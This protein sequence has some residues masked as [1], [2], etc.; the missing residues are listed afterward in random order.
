MHFW[1]TMSEYVEYN[2]ILPTSG[3][4]TII[5]NDYNPTKVMV[6]EKI[7]PG[8]PIGLTSISALLGIAF[9]L[10]TLHKK[11]KSSDLV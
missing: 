5:V 6:E 9:L 10:L 2:V 8:F 11:T 1:M 4:W 3:E 7:I